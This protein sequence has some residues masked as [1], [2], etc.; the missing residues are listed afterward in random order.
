MST[1]E[2]LEHTADTALRIRGA[3][4]AGLFAAA[5]AGMYHLCGL[6][7]GAPVRQRRLRL[8]T[9]DPESLLVEWL[10]ELLYQVEVHAR[11]EQVGLIEISADNRLEAQLAQAP[12]L[13]QARQIKAVTFHD[14]QIHTTANGLET[15]IVFDV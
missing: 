8:S 6:E 2:E 3:D 4:L 9:A 15:T 14:L 11:V 7:Y 10:E 1:F 13:R 5:A 12:L